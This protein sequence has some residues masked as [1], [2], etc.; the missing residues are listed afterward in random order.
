M[1]CLKRM[2]D[3]RTNVLLDQNDVRFYYTSDFNVS[4]SIHNLFERLRAEILAKKVLI[5]ASLDKQ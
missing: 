4:Y 5:R 3:S 1:K 2:N